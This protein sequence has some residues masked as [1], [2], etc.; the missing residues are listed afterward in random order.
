MAPPQWR[1]GL[2][3]LFQLATTVGIFCANLV[4]YG[5]Q[6]MQGWGW[7]LSLGLA[8]VPAAVMFVGGLFLF[9]TPNSLIERGYL[10]EGK[11]VLMRIRG[12]EKVQAELDDLME[13]S[14]IASAIEH[15]FA[16]LFHIRNRPQLVMAFCLPIFQILTGINSIL[17]YAPIIFQALGFGNNASLYSSVFTGGVMVV[18][19]IVTI[20][21]VD[22]FGRRVLLITGGVL[23]VV[24][25][26][27]SEC[28]CVCVCV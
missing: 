22:R 23:M 21:T 4:N 8:G 17:F 11:K 13:A 1:G 6:H 15:P 19:S 18:G 3:M 16:N 9:E 7:R 5:T 24:C 20:L 2:N 25:Q 14:K 10:E 12:T 28:V 27:Y 26:V